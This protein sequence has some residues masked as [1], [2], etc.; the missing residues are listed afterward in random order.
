MTP[1]ASASAAWPSTLLMREVWA[2]ASC[3]KC[4]AAKGEPCREADGREPAGGLHT[5]RVVEV[6]G[7][8][9]VADFVAQVLTRGR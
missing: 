5:Q 6:K 7:S 9:G 3:Q 8:A 4:G 2:G 1:G